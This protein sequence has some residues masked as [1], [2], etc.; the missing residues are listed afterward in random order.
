MGEPARCEEAAQR[1]T[2]LSWPAG[3]TLRKETT[4]ASIQEDENTGEMIST[5]SRDEQIR[6]RVYEIYLERGGEPGHE[7]DDWLQAER[8]T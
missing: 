7:L 3:P 4:M 1:C 6:R 8:E 5:P 2:E